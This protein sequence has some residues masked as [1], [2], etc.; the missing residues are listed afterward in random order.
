MITPES[1]S[2][3]GPDGAPRVLVS[4][5]LDP[6]ER[7]ALLADLAARASA[8]SAANVSDTADIHTISNV[9]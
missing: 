5:A 7:A 1:I 8:S 9:R 2:E 4:S 3:R 6:T